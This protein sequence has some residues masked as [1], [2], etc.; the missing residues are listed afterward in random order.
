MVDLLGGNLHRSITSGKRISLELQSCVVKDNVRAVIRPFIVA[1]IRKAFCVQG[2]NKQS[3]LLVAKIAERG[4]M[5]L[6]TISSNT[7]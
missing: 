6:S 2:H 1:N 3:M 7:M 4:V 5:P